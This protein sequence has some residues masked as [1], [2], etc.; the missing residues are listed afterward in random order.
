MAHLR[1]ESAINFL[2]FGESA[3]ASR[4][5]FYKRYLIKLK[6]FM[7]TYSIPS[8]K[9]RSYNYQV[10][11]LSIKSEIMIPEL[12]SSQNG[13]DVV[14][15]YGNN[16]D[17]LVAINDRGEYYQ[18]ND[19]EVLLTIELIASYHIKK[20]NEITID[21][22]PDV[23]DRDI[24][25]FLLGSAFGALLQQ[26][27]FLP[28]HGSSFEIKHGSVIVVGESG[29]G[30]S[31]LAAAFYQRG[32]RVM[33]DDISAVAIS[34]GRPPLVFPGPTRLKICTAVVRQL[35]KDRNIMD[36]DQAAT[37]PDKYYVPLGDRFCPTPLPVRLIYVLDP[38]DSP[39]ITLT[40]IAGAEKLRFLI[41]NTYRQHFLKGMNKNMAHFEQCALVG[42][43]PDLKMKRIIMPRG[44]L[45]EDRLKLLM[46]I[47]EEDLANLKSS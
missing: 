47:L 13:E 32:Y 27:G 9:S 36:L 22:K 5:Q 37:N 20:G 33:T 8:E 30:K 2:I 7:K 41:E 12:L 17:V 28:L 4:K 10:Y 14:I 29:S 21:R 39:E 19:E 40:P 31:T 23:N 16:A 15:Q 6:S 44:P 35:Y 24:L 25:L 45:V 42:Q 43:N 11:G 26:R 18:I 46:N 1:Q 34:E 3:G 38:Q